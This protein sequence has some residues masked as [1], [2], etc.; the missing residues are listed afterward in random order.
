MLVKPIDDDPLAVPEL[1][2]LK[3]QPDT[4]YLVDELLSV[5]TLSILD[6]DLHLLEGGRPSGSCWRPGS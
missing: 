3:L 1:V 2:R 5:A 4:S 6:N